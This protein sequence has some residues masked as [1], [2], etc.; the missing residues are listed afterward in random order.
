[1]RP[2]SRT[3]MQAIV[4]LADALPSFDVISTVGV[5]HDVSPRRSDLYAALDMT[6]HTTK[7][8]VLLVS[9]ETRFGDVLD[10]LE[11]L[12][13]DLSTHPTV[14]PYVNPISPL[15]LNAATTGKM[16]AAFAPV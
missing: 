5:P 3:H 10:L 4:R 14:L 16:Q 11:H 12:H 7:P 15:V 8:L 13:G 9:D 2:F 1:M 6:A